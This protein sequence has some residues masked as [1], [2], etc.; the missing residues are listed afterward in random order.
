MRLLL[1]K[2]YKLITNDGE[3]I[4][5]APDMTINDIWQWAEKFRGQKLYLHVFSEE[6][7]NLYDDSLSSRDKNLVFSI[8]GAP[9]RCCCGG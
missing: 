9:S 1:Q 4:P 7:I 6:K 5:T 8:V 2:G 3:V